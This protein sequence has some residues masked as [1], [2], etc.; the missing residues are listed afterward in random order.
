ME[1][2]KKKEQ[3]FWDRLLIDERGFPSPKSA[4]AAFGI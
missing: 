1:L 2:Q 4:D 3:V